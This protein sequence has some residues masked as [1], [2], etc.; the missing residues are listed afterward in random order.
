MIKKDSP[1]WPATKKFLEEVMANE[2]EALADPFCPERSADRHRGAIQTCRAII[3]KVEPKHGAPTNS[4]V[5][6]PKA[7][8]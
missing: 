8:Y 7:N 2:M 3:D 6:P 4:F 5:A 1:D